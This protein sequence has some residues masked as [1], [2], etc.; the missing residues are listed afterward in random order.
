MKKALFTFAFALL[1]IFSFGQT[2]H[3]G[4]LL[5]LHILAPNL[6][7]GVTM[8]DYTNFYMNKMIPE[9]EKAF[10]GV[11]GF[12]LKSVRGQDSSSIGV[13]YIFNSEAD[14]NKY[15]NND[16]TMTA[17]GQ[18]AFN[19]V[20]DKLG[21]EMEKYETASDAPNKYNDWVVQ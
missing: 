5:G 19:K 6:K 20:N 18:A 14:R 4:S 12:I 11:K 9:I 7:D 17:A 13:I 2:I 16:G 10:P 8:Q 21:K 15:W 1:C 3:K